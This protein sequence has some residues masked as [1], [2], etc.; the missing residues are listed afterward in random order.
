MPFPSLKARCVV[1]LAV[2]AL[3]CGGDS[4]APVAGPP[5]RLDAVS[6]LVRLSTVATP[7]P[8]GIV[9]KVTDASG[10]PVAGTSVAFAITVGNGSTNPRIALT[11]AKGQAATTWTLGTVAGANELLATVSGVSSQLRFAATGTAGPVTSITIT[12]Q[13][14]RLLVNVDTV[15]LTARGLDAYGNQSAPPTLAPRD[16]TLLAIDSTGLAHVLR[17]GAGTYVVATAGAKTD[18]V[19]VT[20]LAPGQSICTGAASPV[21]LSVGQIVTGVSGDGFCVHATTTGTEYAFIPYYNASTPSA[22]TRVDVRGL[23]VA[24]LPLPS[25][26]VFPVTAARAP[27]Q[28]VVPNDAFES[29]LR[30]RERAEAAV[31]LAN[32]VSWRRPLRDMF[33]SRAVTT[34]TPNVGDLLQLN[35]SASSF[36]DNPVYR[37]GRVAAITDKA[38]VVADTSNPDGGFTDD[39]YRS[40][41]VTFDTL[42]D[43]VDRAAFGAPSDIDNNGRVIM[44]FT[45]AV[46]ELTPTGASG[47]TLGFFYSRDLYPRTTAPGPCAGSNAAEM[48][49]LLVP[50]TGGVINGN[51][52]SKSLV[53]TLTNGT[54]AHEYQHLINASRRM[55]VNG[56]GTVFEERWLDEGLAHIAEELNFFRASGRSARSNLDATGFQDPVFTSAYSTYAINNTRRYAQ[57]LGRTESQAPIG[58]DAFDDDL[59]T[60]GAIWSFLRFA[61]DHLAAGSEDAFWFGLVNSRTTGI[62][63]L[64]AALGTTPYSLLRDWAVSVFADDNA[65]GLDSR[66]QQP[67]WNLRSIITGGNTATPFPLVTRAL[68]DGSTTSVTLTAYGVSFMRFSVATGEDALVTASANGFPLPSTV[69]LAV[70]RVR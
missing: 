5:A 8:G 26:L 36:C 70:M 7:V 64:T 19:L 35:A 2:A 4:T 23:G 27:V 39:E 60:R 66:F 1:L 14:P 17:R 62:A 15:R 57:Y 12:P 38:I 44:F 37:T 53:T 32:P 3:A 21:E 45:R 25:P 6:D 46:N 9:V 65:A 10:H 34:S 51:K 28:T 43:P 54:V 33:P 47:V 69:Q 59:A 63:N 29:Q 11:D 55:Y 22:T 16:P 49:Y 58:F 67:S 30:A 61:A 41:G 40:I 50:D 52:R 18:S 20:V 48:F 56:V 42:V 31:R 24:P 68:T 13:N